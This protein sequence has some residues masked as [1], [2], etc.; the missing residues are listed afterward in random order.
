MVQSSFCFIIYAACGICLT[1]FIVDW[2]PKR[3]KGVVAYMGN[4]S[5]AIKNIIWTIFY[6]IVGVGGS[7]L[8]GRIIQAAKDFILNK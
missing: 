7:L 3:L 2:T 8:L 4:N 1:L 6:I 5:F